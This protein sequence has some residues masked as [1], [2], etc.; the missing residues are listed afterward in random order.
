M[1]GSFRQPAMTRPDPDFE[2]W[3]R[4]PHAE[5]RRRRADARLCR[6]HS[7]EQCANDDRQCSE[8]IEGQGVDSCR[9]FLTSRLPEIGTGVTAVSLRPMNGNGSCPDVRH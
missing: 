7:G 8:Q 9:T 2:T 6:Q 5:A 3:Q 4:Q 1:L